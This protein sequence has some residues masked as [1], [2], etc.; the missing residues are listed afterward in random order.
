[1]NLKQAPALKTEFTMSEQLKNKDF[2][3]PK[4]ENLLKRLH[5]LQVQLTQLELKQMAN[6]AKFDLVGI[7]N[8]ALYKLERQAKRLQR[9]ILELNE[10]PLKSV[11]ILEKNL[12]SRLEELEGDLKRV[13]QTF[14]MEV[15]HEN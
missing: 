14:I 7:S 9:F 3:K 2:S 10:Y 13:K 15:I 6:P 12:E 11:R 8:L 5:T 1:M 4:I